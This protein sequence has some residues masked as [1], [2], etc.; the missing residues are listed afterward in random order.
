MKIRNRIY[1]PLFVAFVTFVAFVVQ[2]SKLWP[3]EV[4]LEE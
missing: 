4:Y 2:N 3:R 1:L